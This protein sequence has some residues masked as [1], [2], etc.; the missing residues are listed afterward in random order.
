MHEYGI[1]QSLIHSV[2]REAAAR[3]ATAIH[4]IEVRVGELSGVDAD[5]LSLAYDTFREKTLCAN[6]EMKLTVVSAKWVCP[7]CRGEIAR[8][9]RLACPICALP[10]ELLA[11]AEIILE[12][13]DMEVPD[14]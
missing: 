13:I 6:A 8:G 5:L 14:V 1:V 10:A 3:D 2:E 4:R 9:A 11:G 7:T 12:R